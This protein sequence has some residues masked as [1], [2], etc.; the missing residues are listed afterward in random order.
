MY[1]NILQYR[2]RKYQI[3]RYSRRL[4]LHGQDNIVIDRGRA[5]AGSTH[6]RKKSFYNTNTRGYWER[7]ALLCFTILT[8]EDRVAIQRSTHNTWTQHTRRDEWRQPTRPSYRRGMSNL[9]SYDINGRWLPTTEKD[10]CTISY[11][12]YGSTNQQERSWH[13]RTDFKRDP[14]VAGH[15]SNAHAGS[16]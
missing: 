12:F 1:T 6:L 16:S 3:K 5:F 2:W 13:S 11:L 15:E 4:Y 7:K 8:W 10:G 14:R 9:Y